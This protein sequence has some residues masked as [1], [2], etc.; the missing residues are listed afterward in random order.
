MK[1]ANSFHN[2][3][4][5]INKILDYDRETKK[6][7]VEFVMPDGTTF[8]DIVSERNIRGSTPQLKTDLEDRFFAN[9]V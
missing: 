8:Q 4:G 6:Y 7:T 3:M 2:N 9:R 1:F 5:T